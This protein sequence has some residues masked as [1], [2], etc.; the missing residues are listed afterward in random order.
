MRRGKE[1]DPKIKDFFRM[2]L[3]ATLGTF[4]TSERY[5][6]VAFACSLILTNKHWDAA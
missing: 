5:F 6:L 4:A 3:R 1:K 2:W